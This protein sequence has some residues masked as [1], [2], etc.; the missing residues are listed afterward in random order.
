MSQ[1]A[2]GIATTTVTSTMQAPLGFVHEEPAASSG[3]R[4]N[5][6]MQK[7]V[8]IH[9]DSLV[10]L[11]AGDIV[12][13]ATATEEWSGAIA[14][15]TALTIKQRAL[16]VAQHAIPAGYYGFILMKGVGVVQTDASGSTTDLMFCASDAGAGSAGQARDVAPAVLA[17]VICELGMWLATD[18]TGAGTEVAALIDCE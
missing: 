7:W 16:G 17:D 8:Y 11:A 6:G 9:N 14:P 5:M 3:N 4:V 12:N 18:A 2:M 15:G 1:T 10:N 13:R